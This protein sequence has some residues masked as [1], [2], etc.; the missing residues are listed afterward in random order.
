MESDHWKMDFVPL[1][2]T[3]SSSSALL[4]GAGEGVTQSSPSLG[5]GGLAE[6]ETYPL[7]FSIHGAGDEEGT[8]VL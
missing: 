5:A 2:P 6:V 8:A 4:C 3:V 7:F 1:R